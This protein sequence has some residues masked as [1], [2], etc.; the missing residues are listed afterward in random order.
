MFHDA[1]KRSFV[2]M[3]SDRT[4]SE[5][6][7]VSKN[8]FYRTEICKYHHIHTIWWI[9]CGGTIEKRGLGQ[10]RPGPRFPARL[11]SKIV[12]GSQPFCL[13]YPNIWFPFNFVS[14]KLLVY[15]SSYARPVIYK[16]KQKTNSVAWARER[17]DRSTAA[18]RRSWHQLLW[19]E[20]VAWSA[21]RIPTAVLSIF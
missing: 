13:P 8:R 12:N 9:N 20:G 7:L 3:A 10:T 14:P 17:T 21:R 11:L 5:A 1:V 15:N 16:T 4:Q 6:A 2:V 19:I 18:S